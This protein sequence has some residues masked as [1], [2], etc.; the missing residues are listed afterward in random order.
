M[1][2]WN[3]INENPTEIVVVEKQ[4]TPGGLGAQPGINK[5]AIYF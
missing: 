3:K 5:D 1:I 2:D 4:R